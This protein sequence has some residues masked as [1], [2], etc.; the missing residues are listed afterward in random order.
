MRHSATK[1]N[2]EIEQATHGM[3]AED[4]IAYVDK[5]LQV[6]IKQ[7]GAMKS[8]TERRMKEQIGANV[9]NT[10]QRARGSK[11][12]KC[13]SEKARQTHQ[14]VL[15][16]AA[17]ST[18]VGTGF[19]LKD[20]CT[21]LKVNKKTYQKAVRRSKD[22]S[23]GDS[24]NLC[25]PLKTRKDKAE[26]RFPFMKKSIEDFFDTPSEL[27]QPN[28][29]QSQ[30]ITLHRDRN[31]K[32]IRHHRRKTDCPGH[33][34][35]ETKARVDVLATRKVLYQDFM[36]KKYD[37][38]APDQAEL[39]CEKTFSIH[40]F[41]ECVPFWVRAKNKR[42]CICIYHMHF[43]K[44][45]ESYR[46]V[47]LQIHKDCS[48][49]CN[50]CKDRGCLGHPATTDI[51][52]WAKHMHGDCAK[53]AGLGDVWSFEDLP[54]ECVT[55]NCSSCSVAC[56]DLWKCPVEIKAKDRLVSYLE[57]A[58]EERKVQSKSGPRTQTFVIENRVHSKSFSYLRERLRVAYEEPEQWIGFKQVTGFAEH[59]CIA[60][61]QAKAYDAHFGPNSKLP[62]THIVATLDFGSNH[63]FEAMEQTQLSF[64]SP[65]QSTLYPVIVHYWRKNDADDGHTL[66]ACA[67]DVLSDDLSHD[68]AFVQA[69]MREVVDY[70]KQRML[71][72]DGRVLEGIHSWSDGARSQ[73]KNR[74]YIAFATCMENI[75]QVR[76]EVSFF[77][78]CHGKGASDSE[79]AAL[80]RALRA[81]Q[82]EKR[83]NTAKEGCERLQ[84]K[85]AQPK[86]AAAALKDASK[87]KKH[88]LLD[89]HLRF[90]EATEID[91]KLTVKAAKGSAGEVRGSNDHYRFG[92][93]SGVDGECTMTW[94]SCPTA[95]EKCLTFKY[96]DCL[97]KLR[98]N[99]KTNKI[100]GSTAPKNLKIKCS[101]PFA[102]RA[103]RAER[104]A[105]EREG[106]AS[107]SHRHHQEPRRSSRSNVRGWMS[108]LKA[109][110]TFVLA[111]GGQDGG[112][113]YAMVKEYVP[114][115]A[116][117]FYNV[118]S[119][120]EEEDGVW[121]LDKNETH[122]C[123]VGE[124]LRPFEYRLAV[125]DARARKYS[126]PPHVQEL[127]DE[128]L[129]NL[130]GEEEEDD[131]DR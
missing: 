129:K 76:G 42:T 69:G 41:N 39:I 46:K 30:A 50:F 128:A 58:K 87:K 17:C 31:G 33:P 19:N 44:L 102:A 99:Y 75:C 16:A 36:K 98:S 9:L 21:L 2:A 6:L 106:K 90:I 97:H 3:E 51:D 83:I 37:F 25:Q 127:F 77:C 13:R 52:A 62:K 38:L 32:K 122:M 15:A 110:F 8:T 48:C 18:M 74:D 130:R 28:P 47:A 7:H 40:R 131:D 1:M 115:G 89:R 63:S 71:A 116:I 118:Y 107:E 29:D 43:G 70:M 117:I 101:N 125:V 34:T 54:V 91:R 68:V 95:C 45:L 55:S 123:S 119:E 73:F 64:F 96:D 78:S 10:L 93:C 65:V 114:Q 53:A 5:L 82:T 66:W 109:G 120:V 105:E 26:T 86:A 12:H 80:H 60:K 121:Y 92:G 126:V 94:M 108:R 27:V 61:G 113:Y 81:A 24:D 72:E 56:S 103:R 111:A 14:T 104:N 20:F 23:I 49:S 100:S 35:C 67:F 88:Q 22:F 79:T 112:L 11:Q 85:N 4:R 57:M 59:R 124:M 84:E